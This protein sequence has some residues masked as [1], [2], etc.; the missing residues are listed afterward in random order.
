MKLFTKPGSLLPRDREHPLL[1]AVWSSLGECAGR[2]ATVLQLQVLA[3]GQ[4]HA[5]IPHIVSPFPK[6]KIEERAVIKLL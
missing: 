2:A 1:S 6:K 5:S 3:A 4:G